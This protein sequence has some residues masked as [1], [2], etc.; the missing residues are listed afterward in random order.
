MRFTGKTVGFILSAGAS[1]LLAIGCGTDA[2]N[3]SDVKALSSND[4]F[5]DGVDRFYLAYVDSNETILEGYS[6]TYGQRIFLGLGCYGEPE[7]P[8]TLVR[9][10][11]SKYSNE[12]VS[13]PL[14]E[15]TMLHQFPVTDSVSPEKGECRVLLGD[16]R[17]A[18]KVTDLKS[19]LSGGNKGKVS[20][21]ITGAALGCFA[22]VAS[23]TKLVATA[24]AGGY[25]TAQTAGVAAPAVIP[26]VAIEASAAITSGFYCVLKT[27]ESFTAV[28]EF[29]LAENQKLFAWAVEN[30]SKVALAKMDARGQ[31]ETYNSLADS[32]SPD[33]LAVA[34]A[35]WNKNFVEAFNKNIE[36]SF[37]NGWGKETKFFDAIEN[38]GFEPKSGTTSYFY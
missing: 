3:S 15:R 17:V 9:V 34:S 8:N 26:A 18:S 6:E 13:I 25:A 1:A 38:I 21:K 29:Q 5:K 28:S 22:A 12:V 33:K 4:W 11:K 10:K 30:A 31:T 19:L 24:L 16:K 32:L 37:E 36:A 7:D 27:K 23:S 35:I 20:E 14:K 2:E